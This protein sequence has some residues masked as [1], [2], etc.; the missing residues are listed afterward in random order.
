M[1][2]TLADASGFLEG[3]TLDRWRHR[4]ARR[5]WPPFS[6]CSVSA[7]KAEQA[8][9]ANREQVSSRAVWSAEAPR[10]EGE[11]EE[12]EGGKDKDMEPW[13]ADRGRPPCPPLACTSAVPRFMGLTLYGQQ[14]PCLADLGLLYVAVDGQ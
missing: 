10:E 4:G 13:A 6:R 5:W 12:E 11:E 1:S 14:L 8:R 2:S 3:F 7:W 9:R